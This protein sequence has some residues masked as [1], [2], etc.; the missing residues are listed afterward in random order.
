MA[1]LD[2]RQFLGRAGTVAALTAAAG[3]LPAGALAGPAQAAEI[4]PL[5]GGAR[6]KAALAARALAA[7]DEYDLGTFA[8]PTNGDEERYPNRIGN[9]SKGLPHNALGEV[10]PAA[11]S[12]LLA[13]LRAGTLAALD[14][15]PLG[16]GGVKLVNPIGG[17]AYNLHGPD[18]AAFSYR[19]PPAFASAETAAE[20]VDCYWMALCRDVPFADYPTS[21]LIAAACDDLSRL[22]AYP[23]PRIGGRVTPQSIFRIGF[24]GVLDGPYPSQLLLQPYRFNGTAINQQVRVPLAGQDFL[25]RYA[26]W[27]SRLRGGPAV[28]TIGYD[29]VARHYRSLR[30]TGNYTLQDAI[31]SPYFAAALI[32]NGLGATYLDDANPYKNARA[33]SGNVTFGTPHLLGLIGSMNQFERPAFYQKWQVHRRIR[34]DYYAGRVHNHVTG[35]ATYPLHPDLLGSA[36]LDRVAA[37]N[38]ALAGEGSYLL[39]VMQPD[40]SPAHPGWVSGHA[41]NAGA[42][43]TVLKA[44]FKEDRPYPNPVKPNADGTAL[45]PY[46]AGVDGPELTIGGEINKLAVVVALGRGATGVHFRS[47][48]SDGLR[49]GEQ[50]ALRE[51]AEERKLLPE[52]SG[53]FTVTKFDGTTVSI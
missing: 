1:E 38:A 22:S 10:D 25:V 7:K 11:Y 53:G 52:Q 24:P 8:Q 26:D 20:M 16:L 51:L 14:T 4:A 19:V 48:S 37:Y 2:R 50:I 49:I 28:G 33:Q 12:A 29:P 40:G 30:D 15:V 6:R 27:L 45:V 17:L 43:A 42:C 18:G 23:G 34:P 36:A 47:D 39:P 46:V 31:T 13:A 9:F 35:A 32:L 41:T 21:P 44:W 3:V 5:T